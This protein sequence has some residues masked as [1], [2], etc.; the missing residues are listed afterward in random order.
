M[1]AEITEGKITYLDFKASGKMP[2]E[3]V[4]KYNVEGTYSDGTVLDVY[5]NDGADVQY[6]GT[7]T[8]IDGTADINVEKC[9]GYVLVA[10]EGGNGDGGLGDNTMLIVGAVV[11][12]IVVAAAGVFLMRRNA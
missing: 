9:S 7:I 3:T 11:V 4:V 8:V 2:H 6:L 10:T 1:R 12:V 5:H